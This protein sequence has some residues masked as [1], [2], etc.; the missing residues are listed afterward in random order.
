M[1]VAVARHP[2]EGGDPWTSPFAFNIK[3][4]TAQVSKKT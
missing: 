4:Q 1:D 2:R 3:P